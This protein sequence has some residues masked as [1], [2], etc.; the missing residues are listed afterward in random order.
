MLQ[1]ILLPLVLYFLE[2]FC[3]PGGNTSDFQLVTRVAGPTLRYMPASSVRDR[4]MKTEDKCPGQILIQRDL[5]LLVD[6]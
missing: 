3:L 6:I 5:F 4:L 1:V 2:L